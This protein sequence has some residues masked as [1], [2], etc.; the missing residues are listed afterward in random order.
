VLVECVIPSVLGHGHQGQGREG[1]DLLPSTWRPTKERLY[2]AGR[3]PASFFRARQ[4]R[5]PKRAILTN[6]A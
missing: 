5:P 3:I 1:I 4:G 6:A 2:A